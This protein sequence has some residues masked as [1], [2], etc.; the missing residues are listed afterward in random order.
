MSGVYVEIG[1]AKGGPK[2]QETA[3]QN[4]FRDAVTDAV[5]ASGSGL[6]LVK[7][8][9]GKGVQ[10]NVLITKLA[11][12]GKEVTCSLI[13]E[14]FEL[15]GKKRFNP[16]GRSKG[17][18]EVPGKLS[19]D[20]GTCVKAAVADLMTNIGPG[21]GGLNTPPAATGTVNSASPLIYLAPFDLTYT[22]DANAAP[23]ALATKTTAAMKSVIDQKVKAN[24][25]RFTQDSNAYTI[26]SGMPAY[27][28]GLK[29]ESVV[30][31]ASAK[32]MIAT[33][34][35]YVAEHP[36]KIMRAPGL[37]GIAKMSQLSK[38]PLDADKIELFAKAAEIATDTCLNWLLK[39]HP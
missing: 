34:I 30:Y 23:A 17:Q 8:K 21:I 9:D 16:G 20:A 27:I 24:K 3:V 26:G 35:G 2:G 32:E 38:S 7:P 5:N 37:K 29:A 14:L 10:V 11:E 12:A 4:A 25:K 6:T 36:N 31:N 39:K 19:T 1:T 33:V 18:A 15:P 13:G 22:K 28:V